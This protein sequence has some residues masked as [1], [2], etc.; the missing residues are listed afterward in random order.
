IK[1]CDPVVM[2]QRRPLNRAAPAAAWQISDRCP[3]IIRAIDASVVADKHRRI[4]PSVITRM[5]DYRVLIR[6]KS[7]REPPVRSAVVR[8]KN[9]DAAGPYA[10]LVERV[11]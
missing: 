7:G 1:L 4:L 10:V 8:A 9:R 6:V 2:I 11:Y 5:K 3:R